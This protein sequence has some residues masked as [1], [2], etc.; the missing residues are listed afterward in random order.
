MKRILVFSFLTLLVFSSCDY[1]SGKRIKGNGVIK[2]ETRT[3]GSFSSIDVKGAIYV[4]IKQDSSTSVKIETDENL[5]DYI[6]ITTNGDI[7]NIQTRS[8]TNPRP[9]GKIK[10]F[11]SNPSFKH[12]EA[13]G[14]CNIYSENKIADA[15]TITIDLSGASEIKMEL[16][17]PAVDVDASGAGKI[18]LKG[19]TRDLKAHGTGA[20]DIYC[21]ELMT[22]NTTIQLSGAGSAQVFASV[23]LDV[24]ITGAADVKYKGNPT[25]SQSVSGAG[26]V[27][28][29]D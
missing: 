18:Y 12:F 19:E 23:K 25:V 9:T 17:A 3:V 1:I 14:A 11:V 2:T 8:R 16:A 20:T 7:L 29:V 21:Y 15:G 27:K 4:I 6:E 5:L 26:S 13:S 28:K 10:V 24:H 22:E